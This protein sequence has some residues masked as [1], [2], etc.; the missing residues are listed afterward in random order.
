M[1]YVYNLISPWWPFKLNTHFPFLIVISSQ[2]GNILPPPTP[3]ML[4]PRWL[5]DICMEYK[6]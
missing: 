2:S 5:Y 6:V 3:P 1:M 4:H